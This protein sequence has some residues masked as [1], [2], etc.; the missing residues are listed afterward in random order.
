MFQTT[1]LTSNQLGRN[2]GE[3]LVIIK[4]KL[5]E[6]GKDPTFPTKSGLKEAV[7]KTWQIFLV[8]MFLLSFKN[9]MLKTDGWTIKRIHKGQTQLPHGG[10]GIL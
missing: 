5:E 9:P 6:Y 1:L 8:I 3:Y 7:V 2:I 4:L 10:G